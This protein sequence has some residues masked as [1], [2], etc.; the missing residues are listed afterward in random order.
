MPPVTTV[1]MVIVFL[2]RLTDMAAKRGG[3]HLGGVGWV[4]GDVLVVLSTS[5]WRQY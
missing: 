3:G 1:M 4:L 2:K 5:M